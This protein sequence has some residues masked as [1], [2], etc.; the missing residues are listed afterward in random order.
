MTDMSAVVIS[1]RIFDLPK[2]VDHVRKF[3]HKNTSP[4]YLTYIFHPFLSSCQLTLTLAHVTHQQTRFERHVKAVLIVSLA[5]Y[6]P[7]PK[8]GFLFSGSLVN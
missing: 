2:N 8:A 3:S 7:L 1:Q 5:T 4:E 6:L